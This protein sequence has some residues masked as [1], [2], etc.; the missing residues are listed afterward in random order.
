MGMLNTELNLTD[1]HSLKQIIKNKSVNHGKF[2]KCTWEMI[3]FLTN[4]NLH[5]NFTRNRNYWCFLPIC[6]HPNI[7]NVLPRDDPL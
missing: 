6:I 2:K 3:R 7:K 1:L 5:S 4:L